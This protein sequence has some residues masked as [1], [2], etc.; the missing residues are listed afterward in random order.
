MVMLL[1]IMATDWATLPEPII[2]NT[3]V[4]SSLAQ[5][6]SHFCSGHHHI[7]GRTNDK[8][9]KWLQLYMVGSRLSNTSASKH[10]EDHRA[11]QLGT[12]VLTFLLSVQ[13]YILGMP[14]VAYDWNHK[15][16][17]IEQHCRIRTWWG[18]LCQ[19]VRLQTPSPSPLHSSCSSETEIKI[20][21]LGWIALK[22]LHKTYYYWVLR[23]TNYRWILRKMN[24]P[25]WH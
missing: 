1:L 7:L 17:P 4:P 20:K 6:S 23:K 12:I 18:P 24:Y 25:G 3:I 19:V 9:A 5:W 14:N 22:I 11:K 13:H 15:L 16:L 10:D 21:I 2:M 8:H